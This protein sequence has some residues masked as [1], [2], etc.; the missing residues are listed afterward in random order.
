FL[1]QALM[2]LAYA[3]A[4]GDPD[5]TTLLGG[6]PSRRH[7]FRLG[8]GVNDVRLRAPWSEPREG[9]ADGAK[10]VSGSLVGLDYGL[11]SLARRRV[12]VGSLPPAPTL[13]MPDRQVF[14]TTLAQ[15]NPID[16]NDADQSAIV[17][18][19]GRG[20]D[21]LASFQKDPAAWEEAAAQ[22]SMDGWRRNAGRWAIANDPEAL[23]SF[24]S[25][26]ELATLGSTPALRDGA[27]HPWGASA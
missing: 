15:M 20:R 9:S 2:S 8:S 1:A 7:E 19:I 13:T 24:V 5:G 16:F 21:R 12:N 25:L 17:A 26:T 18:A 4:I 10:H 14:V 3:L 23:G 6:D 27:R 11:A 22:L